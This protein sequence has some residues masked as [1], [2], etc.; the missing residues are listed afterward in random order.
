MLW[1]DV[2]APK[3]KDKKEMKKEVKNNSYQPS[4]FPTSYK[5]GSEFGKKQY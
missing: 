5:G 1:K 4:K 3:E 2:L